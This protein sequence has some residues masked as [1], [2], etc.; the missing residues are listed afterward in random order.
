MAAF[1]SASGRSMKSAL[2]LAACAGSTRVR[3]RLAMADAQ[4]RAYE[5]VG[6]AA[7]ARQR[8]RW[9]TIPRPIC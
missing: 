3:R 9:D 2:A 7:G 5:V 1:L 4:L 8:L 6:R